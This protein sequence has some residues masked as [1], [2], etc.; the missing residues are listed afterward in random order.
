LDSS[1]NAAE[2]FLIE[3]RRPDAPGQ[4]YDA[5][6]AGDGIISVADNGN[7]RLQVTWGQQI[8]RPGQG[9]HLGPCA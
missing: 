5:N 1:H 9:R 3:R 7:G 8:I 2:F 4:L 6:F